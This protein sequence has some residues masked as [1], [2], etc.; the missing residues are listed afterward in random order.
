MTSKQ[1]A[2]LEQAKISW[3]ELEAAGYE[4]TAGWMAGPHSG[5]SWMDAEGRQAEV[6]VMNDN[7]ITY[8]PKKEG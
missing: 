6:L 7:R 3:A 5:S 2:L 4:R 8:L 1:K